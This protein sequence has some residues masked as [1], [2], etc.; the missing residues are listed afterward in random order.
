MYFFKSKFFW[1]DKNFIR[2]KYK[3]IFTKFLSGKYEHLP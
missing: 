2:I 3:N 1:I